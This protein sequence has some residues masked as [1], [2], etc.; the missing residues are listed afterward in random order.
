[1]INREKRLYTGAHT[2]QNREEKVVG[3]HKLKIMQVV[4]W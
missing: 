3:L 4:G 1:M 2:L